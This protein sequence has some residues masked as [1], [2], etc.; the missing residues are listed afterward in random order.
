MTVHVT[1]DDVGKDV[2]D[3][4]GDQIGTVETVNDGTALVSP[5]PEVGD[6]VT[7]ALGWIDAR[8]L[9]PLREPSIETITDS[10]IRLRSNL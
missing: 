7:R 6:I 10:T 9:Y 4:N 2:I 8:G 3:A 1:V 5:E